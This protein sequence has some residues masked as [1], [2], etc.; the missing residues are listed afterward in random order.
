MKKLIYLTLF[1]SLSCNNS[2]NDCCDNG[3]NFDGGLNN[4]NTSYDNLNREYLIY[5]P[6]IL[7]N[8]EKLPIVINLHGGSQYAQSYMEYT[9]DMRPIA[10]TAQFILIYPQATQDDFGNPTWHL[11][12]EN[13]KSTSVDDVGYIEHIIEEV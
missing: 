3:N 4:I 13:S 5:V 8:S 9:S 10:D 7:D 1:L 6:Q 2:D 12:A 11:G